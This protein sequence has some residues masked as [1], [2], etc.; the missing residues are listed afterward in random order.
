[1]FI[2]FFSVVLLFSQNDLNPVLPDRVLKLERPFG[3]YLEL[4]KIVRLETTDACLI[5]T[6]GLV[7]VDPND[8]DLV[9][10][11]FRSAAK[12]FR[13]SAQGTFIRAYGSVGEG[14]GE[15][16][17]I[18][19]FAVLADSSLVLFGDR[20]MV[21]C[22]KSGVFLREVPLDVGVESSVVADGN[23]YLN[24]AINRGRRKHA[25]LV[26]DPDLRELTGFYPYEP[27]RQLLSFGHSYSIG[28]NN[29][30][31]LGFID[32]LRKRL[33]VYN[34]ASGSLRVL[35]FA[36]NREIIDQKRGRKKKLR[37]EEA[38]RFLGGLDRFQEIWGVG[39]GFLVSEH[40]LEKSLF[41]FSFYEP[42]PDC[43]FQFRATENFSALTSSLPFDWVVGSVG[44]LV[45]GVLENPRTLAEKQRQFKKLQGF[46]IREEENPCLVFAGLKPL[47]S[48]Q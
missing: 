35:E 37:G 48:L 8:G 40:Y 36:D 20:K 45:I 31:A 17:R 19:D 27:A 16:R 11:D 18:Y 14:P 28:V 24:Y 2:G 38:I 30:G 4:E 25:I 26:F 7:R 44:D 10:G 5:G 43:F 23:L 47:K 41:R 46:V 15:L 13:F 21:Q 22:S 3:N 29:S 12:V 9:V 32:F 6:I 34:P 1:M 33:N 42:Q 39:S